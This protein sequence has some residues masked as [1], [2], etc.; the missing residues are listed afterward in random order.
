MPHRANTSDGRQ[1]GRTPA[2]SAEVQ[3][4]RSKVEELTS[5]LDR[6]TK[7]AWEQGFRAGDTAARQSLEA[8]LRETVSALAGTIAEIA[9]QRT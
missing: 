6:G 9:A 1:S 8:E 3:E 7:D 4:L 2:S 5:L